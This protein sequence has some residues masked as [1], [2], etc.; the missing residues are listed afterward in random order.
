MAFPEYMSADEEKHFISLCMRKYAFW[1]G[2][3]SDSQRES[4]AVTRDLLAIMGDDIDEKR[5]IEYVELYTQRGRSLAE[6]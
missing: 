4:D 5:F 6:R 3:T 2:D 1:C